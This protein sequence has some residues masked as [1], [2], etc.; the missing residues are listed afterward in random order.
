MSLNKENQYRLIRYITFLETEIQ[1][2]DLFREMTRE[3]YINNRSRRRDV[4]RWVENQINATVDIAKVIL[5]SEDLPVPDTY[6]DMVSNLSA[7]PFFKKENI[8]PLSRWIRLRNIISHEYLDVKWEAI[9][10][11]TRES[12]PLYSEFLRAVA[13]Y[14]KLKSIS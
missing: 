2:Y 9:K 7:L 12:Q 14:L 4:E 13:D 5:I 1:D 10:K 11:F 3:E 8:V 6:R